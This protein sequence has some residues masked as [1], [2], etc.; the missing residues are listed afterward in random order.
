MSYDASDRS[1]SQAT[2]AWLT[3]DVCVVQVLLSSA[4]GKAVA[5]PPRS[6]WRGKRTCHIINAVLCRV[7]EPKWAVDVVVRHCGAQGVLG[8]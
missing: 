5:K 6:V 4:L 8:G 7:P 1:S 2:R 3:L